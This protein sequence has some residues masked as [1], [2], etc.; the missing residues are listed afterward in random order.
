[1]KLSN[2][3][4]RPSH[5]LSKK[6]KPDADFGQDLDSGLSHKA[7]LGMAAGW[8]GLTTAAG[9][10]IGHQRS[11]TD[12]VTVERVPYQETIQVPIGSHT[13]SGCYQY[14]YGYDAIQGEFG[15][16]YGYD[17]SCTQTVTDY[18]TQ[19]TGRTLYNEIKHHS[20]GFPHSATQGALLGAGVGI[21]TG[22]A[23]LVLSKLIADNH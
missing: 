21:V 16:H 14:H 11:L 18:Q 8:V 5:T 19:Y 9:A 13:E 23:G 4:H 6:P 17:A 20:T 15:Y 2:L 22:A 10:V 7:K 12:V 1:M 3:F